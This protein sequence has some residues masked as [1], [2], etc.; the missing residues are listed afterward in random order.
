MASEP[1][2]GAPIAATVSDTID[3]AS[4]EWTLSRPGYRPSRL[5][6]KIDAVLPLTKRRPFDER[7]RALRTKAEEIDEALPRAEVRLIEAD[8]RLRLAR[9]ND[10]SSFNA[11]ATV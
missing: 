7:Q 6:R 3:S 4:L 5:G 11:C 10:G 8:R 9:P 1:Y 2:I